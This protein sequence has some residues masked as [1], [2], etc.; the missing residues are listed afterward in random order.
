MKRF[1]RA[2]AR[3][4]GLGAVVCLGA[5]A[6]TLAAGSSNGLIAFMKASGGGGAVWV[7]RPD[8]SG[9]IR[10]ASADG[11]PAFS[12]DGRRIAYTCGN[13]EICVMNADGSDPVRVTHNPWPRHPVVDS[14]PSWSPDG[15][16]I[17]F[18][19]GEN[20]RDDLFVVNVDG[21]GLRQLT[22]G[23][24]DENAAWSPDGTRI[25]FDGNDHAG[26]SQIFVVNSDGSGRRQLTASTNSGGQKPAW[27]PDGQQIA[28]MRTPVP[29]GAYHL[30]VMNADGTGDHA[31]TSGQWNQEDPAWS[32]DGQL[33]AFNSDEGYQQN[34]WTIHADGSGQAQLTHGG[35]FKIAPSWQPLPSPPPV[36]PLPAASTTP[37]SRPTPEAKVVQI[38]FRAGSVLYDDVASLSP[39]SRVTAFTAGSRLINDAATVR[40]QTVAVSPVTKWGKKFK[41]G[42]LA[43]YASA[44]AAGNEFHAAIVAALKGRTALERLD[45][46][47]A[48]RDVLRVFT[49]EGRLF[50]T[51]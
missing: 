4:L 2:A 41:S 22:N 42:A 43:M 29:F 32:P 44:D 1:L 36:A 12:P 23:A 6:S 33:I 9:Q 47:A 3:W 30:W 18:D 16:R 34:I 10:L 28:Y 50:A 21:S 31:L 40:L 27:S 14:A 37:P 24:F 45:V 51:L 5:P 13:F 26:I 8:G 11:L 17:A 20:G 25:A 49:E 35:G 48:F 39:S 7:V 19:R 46:R 38:F 15:T